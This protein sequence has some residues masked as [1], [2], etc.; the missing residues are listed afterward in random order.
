MG[1]PR[2]HRKK[3]STPLH[4]W[5]ATRITEEKILMKDYGLATKKDIWR[6]ESLLRKFKSQAK[7][8]IA[9][10][11]G[12]GKKEEVQLMDRLVKLNLIPKG[13]KLDDILSLTIKNVLERR[14]QTLLFRQKLAKTIKQAR[15]FIVHGHVFV[16]EE[17]MDVPSY[18]VLSGEENKISFSSRSTLF[19]PEH[20]ERFVEEKKPE[21]VTQLRED[22]KEEPKVDEKVKKTTAKKVEKKDVKEEKKVVKPKFEKKVEEKP[23]EKTFEEFKEKKE[24]TAEKLV[25]DIKK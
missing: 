14:L 4:P 17:K 15:Q 11:D 18:Y 9:R 22:K 7:S 10:D 5:N 1:H 16:G 23:K 2:K 24:L 25:E 6:A 20:P 8:L 3:Y 21:V 13:S 12:Q 19:N